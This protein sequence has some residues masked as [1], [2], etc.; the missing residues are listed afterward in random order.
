MEGDPVASVGTSGH[1]T[2][3]HVHI[4][5]GKITPNGERKIGPFRY[6]IL[7]PFE[8]YKEI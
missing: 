6:N 1:T 7:N 4:A 8:W 2:G 5:A 3:P